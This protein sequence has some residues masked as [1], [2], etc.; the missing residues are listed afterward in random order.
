MVKTA[1]LLTL[2]FLP[3]LLFSCTEQ[4]QQKIALE[5]PASNQ[6]KLELNSVTYD[7]LIQLDGIKKNVAKEIVTFRE[8]V[9]FK[10]LED[11]LAVK[12][13]GEKTF[14]RIKDH[15]YIAD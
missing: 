5:Q 15:F 8:S 13:I 11:L 6:T 4:S 9:R 14:Y 1:R 10:R 2:L 3:I 7:Q 12:G